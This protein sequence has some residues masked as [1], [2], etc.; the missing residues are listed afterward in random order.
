VEWDHLQGIIDF[1]DLFLYDLKQMDADRHAQLTGVSNRLILDNF[2]KLRERSKTVIVRFP[3]IPG[4]NDS[5]DNIQRM[6]EYLKRGSEKVE[7]LPFNSAAGSK[8]E[9]L[10]KRY[11]LADAVSQ[12]EG[13]LERIGALFREAGIGASVKR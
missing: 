5:A 1:V 6:I 13:E 11:M 2:Q 4:F 7:I 8:Y 12:A 3:L 10:D 9:V